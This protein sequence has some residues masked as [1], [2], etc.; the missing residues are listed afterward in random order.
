MFKK[1]ILLI[2]TFFKVFTNAANVSI[3]LTIQNDSFNG[4]TNFGIGSVCV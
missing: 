2:I 4:P 1:Y 3:T